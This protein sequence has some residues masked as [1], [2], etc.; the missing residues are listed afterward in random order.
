M[1]SVLWVSTTL[2]AS[3][4]FAQVLTLDEV[5][6]RANE[7]VVG[8]EREFS[9]VI[10]EEVYIQRVL[11]PDGSL[12]RERTVVSDLALVRYEGEEIW[13]AFRDVLEVD[14]KSIGPRSGR[15]ANVLSGGGEEALREAES[16]SGGGPAYFLRGL[17][18]A[19]SVP[20]M[21]LTFLHALNQHRFN[22]EHVGEEGIQDVSTWVVRYSEHVSPTVI[23]AGT[24]SLFSRGRLWIDPSTGALARSELLLGDQ[25]SA[26]FS[27]I[28]V[29]FRPDDALGLWVPATLEEAQE[30]PQR[31]TDDRFEGRATYTAFRP[32]REATARRVPRD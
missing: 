8:F 24:L 9:T 5:L 29:T 27:T 14:G 6:F 23:G 2:A 26:A 3:L 21:A 19:T 28:V 31:P 30:N 1:R 10:T 4:T 18:S 32:V 7:T 25:T 15:L 20:T 13:N 22:F 16:I 11:R 17:V 12:V